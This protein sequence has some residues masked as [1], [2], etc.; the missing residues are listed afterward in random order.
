MSMNA[1]SAHPATETAAPRFSPLDETLRADPYPAYARFRA[2]DPIH[3]GADIWG[4]DVPW[5]LFRLA[6]AQA[7]LR[8]NRA[9][10]EWWKLDAAPGEHPQPPEAP[11]NT[12]AALARDWMLFRDPPD[13]TRLR[14]LANT[15]FTPKR[16]A[17]RRPAIA[18]LA[19]ALL[20]AIDP[21]APFDLIKQFAFPLPVLV[22]ADIL[23][24]PEED[25]GKFRQWSAILA[26]AIDLPVGGL[27]ALQSGQDA[28]AAEVS[29]YLRSIIAKRRADPR[30]DLISAMIAATNEGDH[31]TEQELI[32]TI[33]LLL[34]A[35][36]ETTVNL[37]G[38]GTLALLRHPD[39]W[40]T[41]VAQPE[42]AVNATEELLRYDSP[43]QM[44]SRRVF[45]ELEIGGVSFARGTEVFAVL[46]SA[47]RDQA[48]FD[49]PDRLD[50]R[51]A[52]GRIM[53][54]G[55]G[56]HFCLGSPLARL[57]GAIAFET[58]THRLP[59]LTLAGDPIWRPGIILHG[60]QS[61]SVTG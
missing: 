54:F 15:A 20:D 61:L 25:R 52:V 33:V 48:A 56:I 47:N 10:H 27:A 29:D 13:H 4:G 17:G 5:Y 8:D 55:Q 43:V 21:G 38:N 46:G 45:E 24:V 42:L 44:T 31:F 60:L 19:S 18:Q 53:T 40:R 3:R 51:R 49:D 57:E 26:A 32:A 28:M 12:F 6:D 58:L 37:I 41:L 23:G 34:F 36:H 14:A 16:I 2:T 1:S 59:G 9:G 30:D 39:Q 22:I 50:I 35:G 11:A 7:F